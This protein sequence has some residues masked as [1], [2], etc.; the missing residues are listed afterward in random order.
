MMVVKNGPV[1]L[2]L[3]MKQKNVCY[4]DTDLGKLKVTLIIIEWSWSKR[5]KPYRSWDS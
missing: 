1:P 5:A 4:A 2:G 3:G